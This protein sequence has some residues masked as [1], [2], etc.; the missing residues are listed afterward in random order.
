[1]NIIYMY[2]RNIF[3]WVWFGI[4]VVIYIKDN[5][6][7]SLFIMFILVKKKKKSI[8]LRVCKFILV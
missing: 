5:N 1:M 6:F 4:Y 8:F 2:I 7:V 3:R